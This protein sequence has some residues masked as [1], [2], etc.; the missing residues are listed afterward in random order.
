M[1][2]SVTYYIRGGAGGNNNGVVINGS[3]TAPTATQAQQVLKQSLQGIP[4]AFS[5]HSKLVKLLNVMHSTLWSRPKKV[6][7]VNTH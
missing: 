3:T 1:A 2:V 5:M 7:S 6:R 4:V